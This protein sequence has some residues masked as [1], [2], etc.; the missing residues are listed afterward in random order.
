[1]K[2]IKNILIGFLILAE[3]V[4]T[5]YFGINTFGKDMLRNIIGQEASDTTHILSASSSKA[6]AAPAK[7][8]KVVDN[9]EKNI[10]R[11]KYASLLNRYNRILDCCKRYQLTTDAT[12]NQVLEQS[13]DLLSEMGEVDIDNASSEEIKELSDTI[14]IMDDIM[15]QL[16]VSIN[17][18]TGENLEDK[19]SL[20][21]GDSSLDFT[22]KTLNNEDF[23]LSSQAGNITV[24]SFWSGWCKPST[25]ELALINKLY[26]EYKTKDVSFLTI[27]CGENPSNVSAYLKEQK[28]TVPTACDTDGT[29]SSIYGLNTIPCVLI[30]DKSGNLVT[31]M[32]GYMGDTLQYESIKNIID[33]NF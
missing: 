22:A 14:V 30:F 21:K 2:N 11:E 6:I 23:T 17:N 9:S 26:N 28:N 12:I 1:M 10:L 5:I 3:V 31:Q 8:K 19:A 18:L 4:T 25:D 29:I 20:F 16:D 13:M 27:N 15:D 33:S 7:E 24:I 32:E